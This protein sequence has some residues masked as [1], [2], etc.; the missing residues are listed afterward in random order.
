MHLDPKIEVHVHKDSPNREKMEIPMEFAQ[1]EHGIATCN[2]NI[3]C[4]VY[5]L[6]YICLPRSSA[7]LQY[8]YF[9][10][11]QLVHVDMN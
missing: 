8:K 11:T 6:W 4:F 7:Y 5:K 3:K 2:L 1:H 10:C 9:I